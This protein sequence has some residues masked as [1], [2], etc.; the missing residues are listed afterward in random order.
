MLKENELKFF[1]FLIKKYHAYR[2]WVYIYIYIKGL[3]VLVSGPL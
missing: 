2:K 1:N 3:W